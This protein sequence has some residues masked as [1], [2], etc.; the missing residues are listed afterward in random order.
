[1]SIEKTL[2]VTPWFAKPWVVQQKIEKTVDLVY[3]KVIWIV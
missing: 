2:D 1:M 3:E